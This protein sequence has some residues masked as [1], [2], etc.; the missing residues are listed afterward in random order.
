MKLHYKLNKKYYTLL[1]I[2]ATSVA[3]GLLIWQL[4][5]VTD[6]SSPQLYS[7]TPLKK[8]SPNPSQPV[9]TLVAVGD[10]M[11]ARTVEQ[12]M[13]RHDD[14]LYPFRETFQ[15]TSIADITFGNLETPLTEGV[16][17]E[18]YG[19]VFRADPKAA[20][21][22]AYG[23][24]DV[25]S[26]ANNHLK[27]QGAG[28]IQTTINTLRNAGIQHIGAGATLAKA[29][30]PVLIT[31]HDITF[32][33][34]AYADDSF[35]PSSYVATDQNAGSPILD[36]TLLKQDIVL[37]SKQAD[38]IIVSM[39]AGNEYSPTPNDRQIAFAHSAIDNGAQLVI[40]HHP[41]VIQPL[42]E[43]N[44]G[45]IFYSLGNFVF[46]QMWSEATRESVIA[47]ISFT[48]TEIQRIDLT[49]IKIFD[50][51]QPRVIENE[52]GDRLIQLM[53]HLQ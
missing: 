38:V 33:F 45:Y 8:P 12:T 44:G 48:G 1:L 34:L 53:N 49:P 14:W 17:V 41:H 21:G 20:E 6:P 40:G 3:L 19:M 52:A 29:R 24:F 23:G 27:N 7:L 25:V 32:G 46:D 50:Y 42:E 35:M 22:L 11:L 30:K 15:L 13:L 51:C 26:L 47:T 31:A 37:L 43:Y 9:T 2:T 18:P 16:V 10:I 36:E 39:H 5:F 4:V 28:G